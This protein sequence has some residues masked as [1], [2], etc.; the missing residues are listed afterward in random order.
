MNFPNFS[1]VQIRR[2]NISFNFNNLKGNQIACFIF[3]YTKWLVLVYLGYRR[4]FFLL[5]AA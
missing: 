3:Y 2:V 5:L 4:G 1:F